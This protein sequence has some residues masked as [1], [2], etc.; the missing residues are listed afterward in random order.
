MEG[1]ENADT[2]VTKSSPLEELQQQETSL[3]ALLRVLL[4]GRTLPH[5]VLIFFLS[6]A[7]FWVAS[8]GGESFAAIGF[9]SMAGGYL[10]TGVFSGFAIVR[11]LIQLPEEHASENMGRVKRLV[12]SFRICLFPAAMAVVAFGVLISL[13]GEQGVLGDQT[14]SLQYVLGSCFVVWAVVQGRAFSRWLASVS[15][16]RLPEKADRMEGRLRRSGVSTLLLL[17]AAATGVLTL[18]TFVKEGTISAPDLLVD[19]MLLY[20]ALIGLFLLA[21]RRSNGAMLAASNR[22]DL[23]AF[24]TR[25]M[26]L[27]QLFMTWHLLTVWRHWAMTPSVELRLIEELLL[28]MFTVVMAIWGLTSKS[29]RS[30]MQMIHS[31]NALPVGLAFGYAYAGSV[32]MLTAALDNVENVMMLGHLVVILTVLWLQP[33]IILATMGEAATSERIREVVESVVPAP[34]PSAQPH[35]DIMAASEASESSSAE[36][37]VEPETAG[38]SPVDVSESIGEQVAWSEPE[39]LAT[40][41]DWDDELELLD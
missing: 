40:D 13:V 24:S 22:S 32:A 21:W 16:S 28:M 8:T 35:D 31:H 33:R 6:S 39:V 41:V 2:S 19:N 30:N 15:A 25:W 9:L 7:L 4:S 5:L 23:H 11:R 20:A 27:T 14:A 29:Y 38:D 18:V 1:D 3:F 34:E 10:L 12:Y 37:E 17:L 36:A 26:L